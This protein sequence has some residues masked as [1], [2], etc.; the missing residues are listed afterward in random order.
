M[1]ERQL[2]LEQIVNEIDEMY[3]IGNGYVNENTNVD[4]FIKAFINKFRKRF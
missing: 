2:K 4:E 1:T 3:G